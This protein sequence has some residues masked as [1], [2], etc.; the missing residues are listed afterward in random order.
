MGTVRTVEPEEGPA[1]TTLAEA[2]AH[3]AFRAAVA[4]NFSVGWALFG[5]R[6]SLVP[7]FVTKAMGQKVTWVG[8][9][10]LCSSL[11]QVGSLVVVGRF[12]DS[13]GRRPAMIIGSLLGAASLAV[14]ARD[15][16]VAGVLD[17]DGSGRG[18]AARSSAPHRVRWS[19]TSCTDAAVAW[20]RF[21]RW[22]PTPGQITA[23]WSPACWPTPSDSGRL[24]RGAAV[25]WSRP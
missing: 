21:S 6:F 5:L 12:V 24:R 1:S 10:F 8:V 9:G 17:R 3:P 16:L 7:L 25:W 23:R 2:W 4:V 13:T 20:S 18:R 15:D 14:M 22:R 19:A 11:A